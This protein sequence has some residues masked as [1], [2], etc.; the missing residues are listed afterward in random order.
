MNT[1]ALFA[2]AA[3]ACF[4]PLAA[5]AQ[6]T[7]SAPSDVSEVVV[8]AL[9]GATAVQDT[10]A[11]VT[12]LSQ[13]ALSAKAVTDIQGISAVLPQLNI[14]RSPLGNPAVTLHGLG[15]TGSALAFDQSVGGFY[16]GVYIAHGKGLAVA[17]YDLDNIQVVKGTQ[18]AVLG[19]NVSIG[20]FAINTNRPVNEFEASVSGEYEFKLN[21][22]LIQ[23][24]VNI[25]ISDTL[26]VRLAGLYA[27]QQ[28]W[29]K[30]LVTD[31]E[32]PD[33]KT[34]SVRFS[35][36]WAPSDDLDVDFMVQADN[37][38]VAGESIE[39]YNDPISTRFAGILG[40]KG[41]ETTLN[42]V[43]AVGH[44][45]F[46]DYV[47][48]QDTLRSVLTARWRFAEGYELTSTTGY[49]FY[50][51]FQSA[52]VDHLCCGVYEAILPEKDQA[53]SQEFRLTS[54][55]AG[56]LAW[57]VGVFYLHDH[58]SINILSDSDPVTHARIGLPDWGR[59]FFPY[60]SVYDNVAAYAQV[61]WDIT[62]RLTIQMAGRETYETKQA[63]IGLIALR[64]GFINQ[65]AN[66]TYPI[67]KVSRRESAFDPSISVQYRATDDLMFYA[68]YGKG[69]KAGGYFTQ[70]TPSA[71]AGEYGAEVAKTA[72]VG[73]KAQFRGNGFSGHVYASAF[74]VDVND[75]QAT[76]T[77]G[78]SIFFAPRDLRSRGIDVESGVSIGEHLELTAS[79]VYADVKDKTV[80]GGFPYA[81]KWTGAASATYTQPLSGPLSLIGNVSMEYRDEQYTDLGALNRAS[82]P[83]GTH[84]VP[85][86]GPYTR[87][88][89]RLALA[90]KNGWEVAL[91]GR[92]LTNERVVDLGFGGLFNGPVTA[93]NGFNFSREKPRTIAVQFS[94]RH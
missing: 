46:P 32:G 30:N 49:Q 37:R 11:A 41:Y 59:T 16:D 18:A 70:P 68:S 52:S 40:I 6:T 94:W 36:V 83:N 76:R 86:F 44:S 80:T 51:S 22:S 39:P 69:T 8:T 45:I 53:Y 88:N 81:P 73:A 72:E 75:F 63:E 62:D 56:P 65:T 74:N 28:G 66:S 78:P 13:E 92:N 14:H 42:D 3:A 10:A 57:M 55:S 82:I 71:A 58:W 20:G 54:P 9:K 23:G 2:T 84:F 17:L 93:T 26:Q 31:T 85:V 38:K 90:S 48:D 25:P 60:A 89:A 4:V 19:K 15:V 33:T 29:V 47:D 1:R 34:K 12:V 64:P 35:V 7:A 77:A 87:F 67:T 24:A 21:S 91:V 50:D 61:T 43:I 79:A 27:H 5:Q